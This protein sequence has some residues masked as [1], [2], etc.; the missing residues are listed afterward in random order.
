[1]ARPGR[2][3][4]CKS[5]VVG[6]SEQDGAGIG[7]IRLLRVADA[8]VQ[9]LRG[10]VGE[11]VEPAARWCTGPACPPTVVSGRWAAGMM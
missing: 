3:A 8:A 4:A 6:A 2:G 1:M 11:C 5:T 9:S 7:R 10:A